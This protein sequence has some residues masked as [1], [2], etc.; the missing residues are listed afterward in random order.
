MTWLSL[1]TELSSEGM[2]GDFGRKM[3]SHVRPPVKRAG[4]QLFKKKW[5]GEA[6][7]L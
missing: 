7:H 4:E 3:R 2:K 6:K 1:V 5:G